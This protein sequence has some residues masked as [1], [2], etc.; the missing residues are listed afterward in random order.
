MKWYVVQVYSGYE[1][2]GEALARRAHRSR[3][4]IEIDFGEIL[5]PTETVQ[6]PDQRGKRVSSQDLL[7]RLHLRADGR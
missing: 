6:R 1:K 2:Q 4:S 7:S 5:I 3:P